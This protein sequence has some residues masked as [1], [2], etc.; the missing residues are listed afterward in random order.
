MTP[1]NVQEQI[2]QLRD[3]GAALRGRPIS[4]VLEA[5]GAVLDGWRDPNSKWRKDLETKLPAATGFFKP[6]IRKGLE[7][8]LHGWTSEALRALAIRELGPLEDLDTATHRRHSGFDLK[9]GLVAPGEQSAG[10]TPGLVE[11]RCFQIQRCGTGRSRH[12]E[13]R[14]ECDLRG[15]VT[16]F[17]YRYLSGV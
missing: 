10:G 12:G 15:D 7:E 8:A 14:L 6:L 5:L 16:N 4:D 11:D 3:A 9:N 1:E 13:P 2:A 17:S